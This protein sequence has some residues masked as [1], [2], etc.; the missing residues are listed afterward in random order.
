MRPGHIELCL[1][2]CLGSLHL[3]LLLQFLVL[4]P[5]LLDP[6]HVYLILSIH[7]LAE[8]LNLWPQKFLLLVSR[9]ELKAVLEQSFLDEFIL[10]DLHLPDQIDI[11][12]PAWEFLINLFVFVDNSYLL[13]E[14]LFVS[15]L[16]LQVSSV[17]EFFVVH[18]YLCF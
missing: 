14:E 7:Q 9:L 5:L 16:L 15:H 6:L 12:G 18:K 11:T 2:S 3:S 4:L 13:S 8:L 10:N 17:V 1:S